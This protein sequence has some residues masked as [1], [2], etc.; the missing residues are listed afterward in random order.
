[1]ELR[2]SSQ[3]CR[4]G[5]WQHMP[6]ILALQKRGVATH[7]GNL[8]TEETGAGRSQ[9]QNYPQLHREPEAILSYVRPASK[10]T[11]HLLD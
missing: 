7:A 11:R 1:M 2:V 8:S 4:N 5:A 3:D 10:R 9:V 6:V